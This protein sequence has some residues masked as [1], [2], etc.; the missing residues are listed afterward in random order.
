MNEY[1]WLWLGAAV[2]FAVT[3]AA[4]VSL[5]SLW[6]IGGALAAFVAS[7]LGAT[8]WVQVVLFVV[9]SGLLLACLRPFVKKFS[10]P[11]LTP[12]NLDRIV[13]MRAPVTEEIDNLRATGAVKVEGK[14]WTARSEDDAV[15]SPGTTVEILRIEG[16]KVY[17]T[18]VTE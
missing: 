2:L 17:V 6:L 18:P 1:S 7:L 10:Q 9:V 4:T 14:V 12:T 8:L 13:G 11:K 5:V 16:V 3:E 15:I